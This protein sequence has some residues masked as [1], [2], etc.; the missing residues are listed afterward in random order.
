MHDEAETAA[1]PCA[2]MAA[3]I[4]LLG[5]TPEPHARRSDNSFGRLDKQEREAR[6]HEAPAATMAAIKGARV[7]LELADL[8]PLHPSATR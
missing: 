5:E 3:L 4:D 1:L 6:S 2:F 8:S 7:L